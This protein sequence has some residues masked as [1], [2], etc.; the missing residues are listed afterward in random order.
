MHVAQHEWAMVK[1]KN[2]D[3]KR[4]QESCI[5]DILEYKAAFKLVYN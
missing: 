5:T 4:L 2:V 3:F 1:R